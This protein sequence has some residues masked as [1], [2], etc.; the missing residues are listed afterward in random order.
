MINF[1]KLQKLL[2]IKIMLE[3]MD[4]K[5]KGIFD[6]PFIIK[7]PAESMKEILETL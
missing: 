3:K 5:G 4:G 1:L 7:S 2:L 6:I